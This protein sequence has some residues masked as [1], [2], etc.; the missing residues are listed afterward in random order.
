MTSLLLMTTAKNFF[1]ET[2]VS[3]NINYFWT[4]M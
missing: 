4:K 1:V 2:H 3:L